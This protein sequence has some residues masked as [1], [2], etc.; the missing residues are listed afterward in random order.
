MA[1]LVWYPLAQ[2]GPMPN[3]GKRVAGFWAWVLAVSWA[4]APPA[5]VLHVSVV[6]QSCIQCTRVQSVHLPDG[7]RGSKC[8]VHATS[9][10]G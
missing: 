6:Q 7:L 4:S 10:V 9:L 5:S 2:I 1:C 8:R 3:A